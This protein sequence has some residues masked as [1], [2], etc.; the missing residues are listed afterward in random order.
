MSLKV[1]YRFHFDL[2]RYDCVAASGGR[3]V[4]EVVYQEGE[5]AGDEAAGILPRPH[6]VTV[7][8]VRLARR[9]IQTFDSYQSHESIVFHQ[10]S[11]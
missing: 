5:V 10:A 11:I 7:L 4:R 3:V 6:N 1:F 8:L 2:Y 9:A